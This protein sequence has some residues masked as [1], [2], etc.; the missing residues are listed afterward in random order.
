MHYYE[1]DHRCVIELLAQSSPE[2]SQS[3]FF[4]R[5]L[6]LIMEDGHLIYWP[7]LYFFA[8]LS[9]LSEYRANATV[10]LRACVCSVHYSKSNSWAI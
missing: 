7:N 2:L 8:L 6:K 3:S 1:I 4:L 9:Y 5:P 10:Y